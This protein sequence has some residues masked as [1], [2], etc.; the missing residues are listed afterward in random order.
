MARIITIERGSVTTT[1]RTKA[2]KDRLVHLKGEVVVTLKPV[3][4][5]HNYFS[6]HTVGDWANWK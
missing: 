3:G 4:K 2:F 5:G 1:I 6:M